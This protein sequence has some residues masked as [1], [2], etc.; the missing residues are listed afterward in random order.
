MQFR[1]RATLLT[2]QL[3]DACRNKFAVWGGVIVMLS[4]ACAVGM[5]PYDVVW[6]GGRGLKSSLAFFSGRIEKW[7]SG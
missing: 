5:T 4:G 2:L 3:H 1:A 6:S 7:E